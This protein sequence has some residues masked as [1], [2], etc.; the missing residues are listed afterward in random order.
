MSQGKGA[1]DAPNFS[2]GLRKRL[3]LELNNVQRDKFVAEHPLRTLFWEST[4]RCNLACKHCGS[5]CRTSSH[6]PDMPAS[7]FLKAVDSITPHVDPHRVLVVITGGEPLMRKDLE[8]IG[9]E[10]YRREYPWGLVTNG[11]ALTAERL[12][13]LRKAGLHAIT[14]SIDGL[15]ED[16]N[17]MRGNSRSF[18]CAI[19]AARRVA[20]ATDIKSDVVTC[21]NNRNFARL[22]ELKEKLIEAG[23]RNW[24]LFTIFPSGRAAEHPEFRMQ[25]EDYRRLLDY[26]KATRAEGRIHAS[27]CCEG[28]LGSYEG[29]VRDFF[30]NCQAGLTVGSILIN[31]DISACPSIRANYSQ[32][33]IYRDD[34]MT[35]W[36]AGFA[37]Y[38]DRSWM[39]ELA[40]C[41]DCKAFR[42]CHG[43]PMHLRET[44]GSLMRCNLRDLQ[45]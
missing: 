29:D 1:A 8:Q 21:V 11:L 45:N 12:M 19:D 13:S 10:L 39:R 27:Y 32:G 16:H 42:Y 40:P 14:I 25:G 33:N 18:E 23:I 35:V 44:D 36:N 30:Y 28:F 3:L 20:R 6:I 24:R 5:D 31:G 26:I 43:G 37:Q 4:Q 17:W 41:S 15:E 38:R 34:F 22:D 9:L 2:A 7:D